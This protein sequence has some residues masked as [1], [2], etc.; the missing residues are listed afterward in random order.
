MGPL[1]AVSYLYLYT[2]SIES[3]TVL[4]AVDDRSTK[5]LI[6]AGRRSNSVNTPHAWA[7]FDQAG[8]GW[9]QAD[10]PYHR[11]DADL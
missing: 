5:A 10:A 9:I 7:N 2:S 3:I 11:V 4:R 1:P 6:D 8:A